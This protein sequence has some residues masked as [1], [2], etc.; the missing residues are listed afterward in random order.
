MKISY[1]KKSILALLVFCSI[2]VYSQNEIQALLVDFK[3]D[4]SM[5]VIEPGQ[6]ANMHPVTKFEV[7]Y[8]IKIVDSLQVN[9]VV[10]KLGNTL[11]GAE[12]FNLSLNTNGQNLPAGVSLSY[13]GSD[14]I[15]NTGKYAI[16]P[17]YF[18]SAKVQYVGGAFSEWKI[19]TNIQ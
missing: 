18:A 19:N 10:L 17:L 6:N 14:L 1:I 11:N 4:A 9:S 2:S 5:A 13:S 15:I 8:H 16:T 7:I 3:L 12:F